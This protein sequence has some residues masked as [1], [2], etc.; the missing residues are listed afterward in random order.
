MKRP[1]PGPNPALL[2]LPT[3]AMRSGRTADIVVNGQPLQILGSVPLILDDTP[4]E[5]PVL[6]HKPAEFATTT[7]GESFKEDIKIGKETSTQV[8]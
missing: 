4:T 1:H 2:N 5:S 3:P 7:L 8:S 6:R